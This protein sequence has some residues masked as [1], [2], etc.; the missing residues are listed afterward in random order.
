MIYVAKDKGVN[1][2][3]KDTLKNNFIQADR[4]QIKRVIMNLLSNGIKYAYKETDLVL[5]INNK[6]NEISFEF[7]NHSP[8]IPEEKQKSIFAQYVSYASIHKELGIGLGLY[9]SQ[10]IIE[11]HQGQI[12]VNSYKDDTNVFGFRIPKFQ[13]KGFIKEICF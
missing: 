5:N 2:I 7:K 3:I 10:K 1:I 13:E 8:Y 4:V 9:A 12:Y 11:G 6:N